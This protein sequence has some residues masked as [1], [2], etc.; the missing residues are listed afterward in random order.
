MV[1]E[2]F[3]LEYRGGGAAVKSQASYHFPK[4]P[5]LAPSWDNESCH[6][7]ALCSTGT[8]YTRTH[9]REKSVIPAFGVSPQHVRKISIY[10][11]TAKSFVT[12]RWRLE[13]CHRP[14]A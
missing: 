13:A 5:Q 6:M 14:D 8:T 1:T 3:T 12:S 2:P 10:A 7:S 9:K 11:G 4:K